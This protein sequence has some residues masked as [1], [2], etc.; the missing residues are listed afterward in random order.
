MGYARA[1]LNTAIE[2]TALNM[3]LKL[4]KNLSKYLH[5]NF[6]IKGYSNKADFISDYQKL[7]SFQNEGK[8]SVNLRMIYHD[9]NLLEGTM[10]PLAKNIPSEKKWTS[11]KDDIIN[12]YTK[13]A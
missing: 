6:T 5:P 7:S 13:Y 9:K 12:S 2:E 3:E 1:L 11:I 8:D 4:P 10:P